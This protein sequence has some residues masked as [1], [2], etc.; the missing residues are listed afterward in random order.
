M[1]RSP[2]DAGG[3]RP[4]IG[5]AHQC[6]VQAMKPGVVHVE[7]KELE[8]LQRAAARLQEIGDY[9]EFQFGNRPEGWLQD[10]S[11]MEFIAETLLKLYRDG[12]DT[13]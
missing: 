8:R 13:K 11:E 4:F 2:Y 10:V 5:Y 9:L 7:L 1:N 3:V 12:M 6:P